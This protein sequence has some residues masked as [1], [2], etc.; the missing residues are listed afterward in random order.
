MQSRL[1]DLQRLQAQ[2]APG[3]APPSA[4][5]AIDPQL[6]EFHARIEALRTVIAYAEALAEQFQE[7]SRLGAPDAAAQQHNLSRL[8]TLLDDFNG[9]VVRATQQLAEA[10]EFTLRRD[11]DANRRLVQG[12]HALLVQRLYN[13]VK[14]MQEHKNTAASARLALARE[15]LRVATGR[16]PTDEQ[17]EAAV[18]SRQGGVFA[19]QI[20]ADKRHQDAG[21]ALQ[22]LQERQQGIQALEASLQKLNEMFRDL[23]VLVDVQGEALDGIEKNVADAESAISSALED[24]IVGAK[25]AKSNRKK[26]AIILALVLCIVCVV[27]L[28]LA[29][30]IC[31]GSGGCLPNNSSSKSNGSGGGTTASNTPSPSSQPSIQPST[32]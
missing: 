16:E 22:Y 21:V 1:A 6:A 28:V 2:T 10:K 24:M 9:S 20:L 7:T 12:M 26:L 25:T 29:I 5:T 4:P 3:S 31:F 23:A 18:A 11:T 14:I 13:V 32:K 17:V 30:V 15:Q 27:V 19:Q 8:D